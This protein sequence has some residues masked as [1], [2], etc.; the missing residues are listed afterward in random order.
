MTNLASLE[1]GRSGQGGAT[2]SLPAPTAL[3]ILL[4]DPDFV[5]IAKPAGFH[6]HQPERPR[7]R[8]SPNLVCLS[9]LRR[10]V[11]Q[12]V[13]PVHRLDV[14]TAGA[15]LFALNPES[16]SRLGKAFAAGQAEKTY[17]AIVRGHVPLG[18]GTIDRP[19][20]S[21][22]S[23]EMVAARTRWKTIAQAE[24]EGVAIGKRALPARFSLMQAQPE[25]GRHHQIRRHFARLSHPLLGDVGH[26]D[27]YQNRFARETLGAGGLM[28]Q[29]RRLEFPH[30]RT[31]AR[32]AVEAPWSEQW[33]VA[34]RALGWEVAL[35]GL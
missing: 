28:L 33:L 18:S 5:A 4:R 12:R 35:A 25:T 17:F 1:S 8:V 34:I 20:M 29:A 19:L 16:A 22:S 26:G 2:R 14:A 6:V 9:L 10:Q 24:I 13:H 32:V 31:G 27:L 11:R 3:P 7:P 23:G 30:P 21:D 15:L